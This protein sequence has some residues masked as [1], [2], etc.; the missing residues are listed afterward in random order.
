MAARRVS[1][2]QAHVRRKSRIE[3]GEA[4]TVIG[5]SAGRPLRCPT[6]LRKPPVLSGWGE[7]YIVSAILTGR[8]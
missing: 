1:M 6:Q 3:L 8:N 7:S 4:A 2:E 5:M